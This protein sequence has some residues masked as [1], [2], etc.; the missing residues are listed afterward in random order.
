MAP[1][2]LATQV[3]GRVVDSKGEPLSGW[4]LSFRPTGWTSRWA[5]QATSDAR[6][7][8]AVGN[9]PPSVEVSLAAPSGGLAVLERDE[10]VPGGDEIVLRVPDELRTPATLVG[11]LVDETGAPVVEAS[12]FLHPAVIPASP[13]GIVADVLHGAEP[14]KP[15]TIRAR[16]R[17]RLVR[18]LVKR[19]PP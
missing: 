5:A 3:R 2:A 7:A 15:L 18:R 13:C 14:F 11:R 19:S 4:L 8:F 1:P 9:C 16:L 10:I 12:V 17:T 6:G